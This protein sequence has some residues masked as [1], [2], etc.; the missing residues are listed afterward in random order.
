ME[1]SLPENPSANDEN[2]VE[3]VSSS[4]EAN[5]IH[6]GNLKNN[7]GRDLAVAEPPQAPPESAA[8]ATNNNKSSDL[9]MDIH[10]ERADIRTEKMSSTS[11]PATEAA[12]NYRPTSVSL[13][14]IGEDTCIGGPRRS[15]MELRRMPVNVL[16]NPNFN[17]TTS[18]LSEDPD[19][20]KPQNR[21]LRPRRCARKIDILHMLCLRPKYT[22]RK[23]MMLSFGSITIITIA[24]VV[25]I[26]IAL[27]I[28]AGENVKS[29]AEAT[30]KELAQESLGYRARYLSESLTEKL[31]LVNTVKYIYEA[32]RDRFD[33]HPNPTD[34]NVPFFDIDTNSNRYPIQGPPMPLEWDVVPNVNED[35]YEEYLQSRWMIYKD[36]PVDTTNAGFVFQ[37]ACDPSETDPLGDAYWPNCTDA[38]NDL[39]TGGVIAPSETTEMYHRKGSDMV[40]FLRA[41]FEEWEVIRDVGLYFLN[42]GA[43]AGLN[44]PHYAL[45]TQSSYTSIGCDWLL[46]SNPYDPSRTIGT[47]EMIKNCHA[48]GE[49]VSNR[50]FNPMERAWCRD[51]ALYPNKIFAEAYENAWNPGEWILFL[52]KS[53]YDRTT[54]DFV[55][56]IYLGIGLDQID[57]ILANSRTSKKAE[58]SVIE[59]TEEGNIIASSRNLTRGD[60]VPIYEAGLG[61]TKESYSDL[62]NLVDFESQWNPKDA[63]T[64]FETFSVSDG[65]YFVSAYPM[66]GIPEE[67]DPNY[68]PIFFVITSYHIDDLIESVDAL[69]E[70]LN[71]RVTNINTFAVIIGLA[72]LAIS[73]LI[74]FAMAHVLTAPLTNMNKV[75][76]EIVG[77]FGDSTKEDEIRQS[78][79]VSMKSR[80]S[81]QTELSDVVTEFNK[82]VSNFSGSSEAKSEKYK[83]DDMINEFPARKELWDLYESRDDKLFKYNPTGELLERKFDSSNDGRSHE[84]FNDVSYSDSIEYL[85]VGPNHI[86]SMTRQTNEIAGDKS[87]S[88]ISNTRKWSSLFLWVVVLIVTPLLFITIFLT[89]GVMTKIN[90]ELAKSTEDLQVDYLALHKQVMLSYARLRA[91][92]VSGLTENSS[93]D[94]HHLTRYTSW[95][96][97]GALNQTPSFT[98]ITT[99]MEECKAYSEDFEKCDYVRENFVCDC[100]WRERGYADTCRNY[101]EGPR[102]LLS[103]FWMSEWNPADNGDRYATNFPDSSFSVETTEWWDDVNSVPGFEK[104]PSVSGYDTTYDRLR[105][106]SALPLMQPLYHYGL[107]EGKETTLGLGVGFEADGTVSIFYFIAPFSLIL[108]KIAQC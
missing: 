97:F 52:G 12:A 11:S 63:Q 21:H 8:V 41:L 87:V 47:E 78:G 6:D 38:N 23:Q 72:G 45:S 13:T 3:G 56:C 24:V 44:Y 81:P 57:G 73:T 89:A 10:I 32:T 4:V 67:Y 25:A 28:A 70:N 36:I 77:S 54:N 84:D 62:F 90:Y 9:T 50:L 92:Y 48:D 60:K 26:C 35:N 30:T 93:N 22:L 88:S 18:V 16:L 83:D 59:Y 66:P 49:V 65:M 7:E 2:D 107:G 27:S 104:G 31:I 71:N 1:E 29:T 96:L 64:I 14:S 100:A 82:M 42:N 19:D 106:L 5:N 80:C 101:T 74:I 46:S 69:N 68:R 108:R 103:N 98:Q 20:E 58:A 17:E 76:N 61:L 91:G 39:R 33:G 95:L 86:S 99:G 53:V 37:G 51:Q 75:A 102:P 43:G 85:H 79:E 105:V 55:A 94:L 15:S 34:D 40:P